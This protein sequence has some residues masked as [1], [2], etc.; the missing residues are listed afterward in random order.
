MNNR[1]ARDLS[2]Q[3][4]HLGQHIIGILLSTA[5]VDDQYS[6][7]LAHF[8]ARRPMSRRRMNRRDDSG[9]RRVPK[10]RKPET[11]LTLSLF[12]TQQH[13]GDGLK[14]HEGRAFVNLANLGVTE[15]FFGR[16]FF[17]VAVTAEKFDHLRSHFLGNP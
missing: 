8:G 10:K 13:F 7:F 16:V 12:V 6:N 9:F 4:R 3:A 1:K 5:V 11:S 2:D 14:L 15:I 17:G